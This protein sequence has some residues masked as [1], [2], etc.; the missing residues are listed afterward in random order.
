MKSK[1]ILTALIVSFI[2]LQANA[3]VTPDE[4]TSEENLRNSGY[5]DNII[6]MVQKTK[7]N[8]RG[9]AYKTND[10]KQLEDDFFLVRWVKRVFM[11]IDPALDNGDFLNHNIKSNPSPNDL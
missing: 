6:H 5:S 9:E 8:A 2:S 4:I 10:Q 7:A 11:Y 1:F 3:G